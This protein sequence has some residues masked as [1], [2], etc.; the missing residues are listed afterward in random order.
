MFFDLWI[1]DIDVATKEA[2]SGVGLGCDVVSMLVPAQ[3]M[4]YQLN[5]YVYGDCGRKNNTAAIFTTTVAV[6]V[7]GLFVPLAIR[8]L[9]TICTI[10]WSPAS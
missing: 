9:W 8:I 5:G 10:A 3:V 4:R 1:A 7:S 6:K 2:M